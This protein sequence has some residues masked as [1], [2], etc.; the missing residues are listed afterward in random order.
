MFILLVVACCMNNVCS[1]AASPSVRCSFSYSPQSSGCL[2]VV[3]NEFVV[4]NVVVVVVAA[5]HT[6]GGMIPL[7]TCAP[8]RAL[9][10][11][12]RCVQT[13]YVVFSAFSQMIRL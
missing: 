2:E 8:P 12:H 3:G 7:Q 1:T 9:I 13:P 4:V 6:H 5:F 10:Y 11:L